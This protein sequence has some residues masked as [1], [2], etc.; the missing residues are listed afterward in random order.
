MCNVQ[1]ARY[2]NNYY[3]YFGK[4][5]LNYEEIKNKEIIK[6]GFYMKVTKENIDLVLKYN[7]HRIKILED[8]SYFKSKEVEKVKEY[9][10]KIFKEK[11]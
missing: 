3:F 10:K 8:N 1:V 4:Y 7:K 11:K 5:Y 2:S 9:N 6:L